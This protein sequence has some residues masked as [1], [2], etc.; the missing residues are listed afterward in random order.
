MSVGMLAFFGVVAFLVVMFVMQ[1]RIHRQAAALVGT[2]PGPLPPPFDTVV[3]GDTLLWF[4]SPTCGPCRA[5]H[6]DVKALEQ[7]GRLHIVDVSQNLPI[8]RAF[9]VMATPT[10]V[11]V[12]DGRIIAVHAGVLRRAALETLGT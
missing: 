4:H 9:S 1:A 3:Q 11:R 10:T 5:M 12:R 6:A 7:E 2:V 8:A